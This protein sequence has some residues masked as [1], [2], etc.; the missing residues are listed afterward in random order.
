MND[1]QKRI[2][3]FLFGCVPFRLWLVHLARSLSLERLRVMGILAMIPMV[4]FLYLY[5]THSR[6]QG[7]ET[8][9]QPIWWHPLR[10]VHFMLYLLFVVT[11]FTKPE[12]AWLPLMTDVVIGTIAFVMKHTASAN[13]T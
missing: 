8:F 1:L 2:L 13:L 3:L 5:A 12:S 11:V 10:I 9:Q 4:G 7:A 6:L